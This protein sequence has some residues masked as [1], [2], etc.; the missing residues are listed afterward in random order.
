MYD[1][2]AWAPQSGPAAGDLYDV[3]GT[4]ATNVFAV[5]SNGTILR[6]APEYLP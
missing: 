1:G 6:Y 3:W 2:S 5:G 4:S